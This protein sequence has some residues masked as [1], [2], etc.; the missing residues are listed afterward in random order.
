MTT[1]LQNYQNPEE[2]DEQAKD[3]KRADLKYV[4]PLP[5][6]HDKKGKGYFIPEE[7]RWYFTPLG[8]EDTYRVHEENLDFER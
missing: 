3:N 6:L 4:G 1:R 8:S 2:T 5:H 7:N